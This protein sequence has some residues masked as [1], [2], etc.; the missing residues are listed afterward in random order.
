MIHRMGAFDVEDLPVGEAVELCPG[1]V[2]ER[3]CFLR[4]AALALG[5]LVVPGVARA[6]LAAAGE[7]LT[8]E[9]FLA[10]VIPIAKAL[11]ADTSLLG[12]DRYLYALAAHAVRL[13]DVPVPEQRPTPGDP[14]ATLGANPG[15]DPF[16]VLHW[17]ME[18]GAGIRPHAHTYG[19]V[20]TVG[21]DGEVRIENYEMVGERDF[22]RTGSFQVRRTM[23]QLLGPRQVNVVNL[24]RGYVH[25]FRA[26]P[27]GAR[28]LDL[29]TRIRPKQPTPYLSIRAKPM[30]L[31]AGLYEA[32][33]VF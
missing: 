24:E 5:G 9:Q 18:P 6:G 8:Y 23:E 13:A 3:R 15:G 11:V 12:Q 27:Q 29:T 22:S 21:L 28:G 32:S 14:G 33:W 26:G 30:E 19:N 10:E 1:V 20:M 31:A 7:R 4:T 2:V 17:K 25:G 16:T